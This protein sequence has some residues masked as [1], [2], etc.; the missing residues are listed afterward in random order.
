MEEL[1][2]CS[3]FEKNEKFKA[4]G[5]I[6]DRR[7]ISTFRH[8]NTNY[9]AYDMLTNGDKFKDNYSLEEFNKF[10]EY[11]DFKLSGTEDDRAVTREILLA[12]YANPIITR[13]KLEL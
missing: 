6:I 4:L 8:W 11:V 10:R 13:E 12:M 1:Q 9:I 2:K 7:I 5:E 3:E